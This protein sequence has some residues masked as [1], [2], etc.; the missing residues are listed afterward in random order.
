MSH[1]YPS[2]AAGAFEAKTHLS[3]LLEEAERGTV[4][5]VT[6]R[7]RPVAKLVPP[8]AVVT[9]PASHAEGSLLKALREIRKRSR[10][11]RESLSA[12]VNAGRR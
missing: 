5:V 9:R 2:R 8:D 1:P 3:R 10:P 11:G 12:L 7:G 6:R 4:T